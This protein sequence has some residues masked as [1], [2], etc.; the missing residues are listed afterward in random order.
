MFKHIIGQAIFQLIILVFLVF[1]GE[2]LL[3]EFPDSFDTSAN[4]T[5]ELKYDTDG[6]ARSGRM[7]YING[8]VDY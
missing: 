2:N 1:F 8:E 7:I 4:F 3:V 5:R 6:S